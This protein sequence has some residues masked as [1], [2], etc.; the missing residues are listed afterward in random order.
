MPVTPAS[1]ATTEAIALLLQEQLNNKWQGSVAQISAYDHVPTDGNAYPHL[2][3]HRT[4]AQGEA[5]EQCKG[6]VRYLMISQT[7]KEK[8]P[9]Q[10]RAMQLAICEVLIDLKDP[11]FSWQ[12]QPGQSFKCRERILGFKDGLIPF[13]EIEFAF[14]DLEPLA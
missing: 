12:I 14:L 4:E 3:V 13:F 5:L 6:I 1:D 10:F 2:V 7:E 8:L 9:G 11:M